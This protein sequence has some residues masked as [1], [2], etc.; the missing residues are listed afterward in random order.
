[1]KHLLRLARKYTTPALAVLAIGSV[2]AQ[3]AVDA[4]IDTAVTDQT[5]LFGDIKT[6]ILAVVIF[7]LAVSLLKKLRKG[8]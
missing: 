4:A 2:N 7:M 5:T 6:Y 3:A 8:A 1:M